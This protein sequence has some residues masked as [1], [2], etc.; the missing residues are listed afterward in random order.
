MAK[1]NDMKA[2]GFRV[3][4]G[5]EVLEVIDRD[6]PGAAAGQVVVR[7]AF[8]GV[9]FAEVQHRRGEFGEPSGVDGYDVPG[10]EATGIVVAVG[11]G[12]TDLVEGESVAAYLPGF[13]GYA[14]YVAADARFVRRLGQVPAV[15]GAGVPCVYPT[16]YGLVRDAGRLRAGDSVV[17][18]AATGGVG[19]A[20]AAIAR[21]GGASA[22]YG[23][24]GSPGKVGSAESF[25]YDALFVRDEFE[26]GIMAVTSGRGVDLVLDPVG[27][28]VR[29]ASLRVLAPFGR[30]VVYGDLARSSDWSADV[31]DL[32]KSNRTLAGYN[33]GDVARRS[34]H[35]IGR[36][37]E[38]ALAALA[39]GV[40]PVREP[41]VLALVDA[42][43]AHRQLESGVNSGKLVLATGFPPETR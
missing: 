28:A 7:V 42:A 22:V 34:P 20:V 39:D 36:Y 40:L 13:G 37:L 32:W 16:A 29:A 19:T 43:A 4:G 8:A 17:V 15:I 25:G 26:A 30:V 21:A 14:E 5:V 33:I 3:H 9:N 23:T 10:L 1:G 41:E 38:E 12:V 18:H 35:T 2:L 24:V 6:E 31:W 27:G 11:P